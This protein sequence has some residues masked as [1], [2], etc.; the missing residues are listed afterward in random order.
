MKI[1]AK[2]KEFSEGKFLVV[3]RDGSIPAWPHF[4]LGARDPAAPAALRA[5]ADACEELKMDPEYVSSLRDLAYDFEKY[6]REHG[7]GD[8]DA[9]PHRKDDPS[10]IAAMRG[11]DAEILVWQ[12][13]NEVKP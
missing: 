11:S 4:V 3:R 2:T 5:Y 12:S 13:K 10:V 8:A 7:T 9:A 6:R 1:W